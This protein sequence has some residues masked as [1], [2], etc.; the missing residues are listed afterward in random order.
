MNILTVEDFNQSGQRFIRT[1]LHV[2]VLVLTAHKYPSTGWSQ[3][4]TTLGTLVSAL[5][6]MSDL[7]VLLARSLD[8]RHCTLCHHQQK[9]PNSSC[10][11]PARAMRFSIEDFFGIFFWIIWPLDQ[12]GMHHSFYFYTE[13]DQTIIPQTW[14]YLLCFIVCHEWPWQTMSGRALKADC[15]DC[16]VISKS[17]SEA[18]SDSLL[19]FYASWVARSRM[20]P[21]SR[22]HHLIKWKSVRCQTLT[23]W[24]RR[25]VCFYFVLKCRWIIAFDMCYRNIGWRNIMLLLQP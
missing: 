7:K 6:A 10:E 8:T 14:V 3:P 19:V 5:H 2:V 21:E 16:R 15:P 4:L 20:L 23:S 12:C 24:M 25:S 1:S 18:W 17:Q 13:E 9:Y 22:L 11:P